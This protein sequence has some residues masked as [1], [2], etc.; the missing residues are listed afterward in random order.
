MKRIVVI[1]FSF[2]IVSISVIFA[3]E[4]MFHGNLFGG[5]GLF[6]GIGNVLNATTDIKDDSIPQMEG[7]VLQKDTPVVE[8]VG[9]S[10]EVDSVL[11]FK[12]LFEVTL[13]TGTQ[14]G[15]EESG[16]SIY[17]SD[18]KTKDKVSVLEFCSA[19]QIEEMEEIPA[20]FIYDK[21]TDSLYLYKSG[22][23]LVYFKIYDDSGSV[24][25]YVFT[26]PVEMK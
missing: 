4:Y 13:D 17:L 22:S 9:D 19:D 11:Q 1:I 26:L 5:E 6:Q 20:P 24:T 23:Y 10:Y 25:E 14:N 12:S 15:S 16:F 3:I 21:E 2:V 8:Y 18:I 7:N